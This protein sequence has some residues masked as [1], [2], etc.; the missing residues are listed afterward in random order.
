[1]SYVHLD[2]GVVGIIEELPEHEHT[3]SLFVRCLNCYTFGT[4]QPTPLL[5]AAQCGNCHGYN[6]VKYYPACCV[7]AA[8]GIYLPKTKKPGE[9]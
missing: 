6:T 4:P 1:M 7:F 8:R 3:H 9:L 2:E 5:Q